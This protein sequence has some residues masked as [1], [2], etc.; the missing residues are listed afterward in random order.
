MNY[1]NLNC[2]DK[3]VLIWATYKLNCINLYLHDILGLNVVFQADIIFFLILLV[4]CTKIAQ[5]W[6]EILRKKFALGGLKH[7]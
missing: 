1:N 5:I 4:T 3:N 6:Q 2:I 7:P